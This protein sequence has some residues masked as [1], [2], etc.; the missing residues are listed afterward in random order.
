MKE[1]LPFVLNDKLYE[2]ALGMKKTREFRGAEMFAKT[3]VYKYKWLLWSYDQ[4]VEVSLSLPP[5]V[6]HKKRYSI[7]AGQRTY[8]DLNSVPKKNRLPTSTGKVISLG[9]SLKKISMS[10]IT[11][12]II[13]RKNDSDSRIQKRRKSAPSLSKNIGKKSKS[14]VKV[15]PK[16]L[17]NSQKMTSNS[18][19][20]RQSAPSIPKTGVTM[21]AFM[22]KVGRIQTEYFANNGIMTPRTFLLI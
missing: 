10:D 17:S 16:V 13:T 12:D 21:T 5:H 8:F 4:K 18:Q 15:D 1:V 11:E 9:K 19:N 14:S 6:E 2:L 20:W 7:S 22:K 3:G